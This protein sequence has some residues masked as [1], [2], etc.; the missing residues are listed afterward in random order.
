MPH[1]V[2]PQPDSA[3]PAEPPDDL[4]CALCHSLYHEPLVTPCRHTFCAFCL[5]RLFD[6]RRP[7]DGSEAPSERR[8]RGCPMCRQAVHCSTVLVEGMRASPLSLA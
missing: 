1:V 8:V 5:G 2:A 4:L 7:I 6:T 3:Y